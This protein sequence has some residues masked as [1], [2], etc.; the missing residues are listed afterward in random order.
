MYDL[1]IGCKKRHCKAKHIVSFPDL[2]MKEPH[3]TRVKKS[4]NHEQNDDAVL[5]FRIN[6]HVM[7]PGF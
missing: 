4:S 1:H 6:P 2:R 3:L 7:L 5:T